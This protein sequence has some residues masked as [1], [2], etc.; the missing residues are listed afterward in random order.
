VP[1][2]GLSPAAVVDAALTI[3]DE[4]GPEA[5]TLSAVAVRTGVATPSLYKHVRNIGE[6]RTLIARRV[7]EEMTDLVGSAVM[8]RGGPEAV[9]ALMRVWRRYA[10]EHPF[11]Y[12]AMPPAPLTDPALAEA[13]GRLMEVALATLRGC[14][15]EGEAALHAARCLRAAVHGFAVLEVAGGFGLPEDLNTTYRL[16]EK[17]IIDGLLP[18]END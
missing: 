8:G 11:R 4:Q 3:V 1:R 5:L 12:A 6:L 13:G 17:T 10:V 9:T 16:L 2:A 14:G 7:I 15:L 18:A